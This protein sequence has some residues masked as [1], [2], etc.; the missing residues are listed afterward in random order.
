MVII[1][2]A[3]FLLEV[4]ESALLGRLPAMPVIGEILVDASLMVAVLSVLLHVFVMRPMMSE[5][6]RR[7]RAEEELRELNR[8]L[9]QQVAERT[10]ELLEANR[11]LNKAVRDQEDVSESLRRNSAFIQS[12]FNNAGCLLLAFDS[13]WHGCV[14]VNDRLTDLLGYEQD[15]FAAN[16][17]DVAERLISAQDRPG[18][19]AEVARITD[20]PAE[21]VVWRSFE[22]MTVGREPVLLSVGLSAVDLT[23]TGQAKTVLLTA[24]PGSS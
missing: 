21:G 12:V 3:V 22:F 24:M 2:G 20:R 10:D 23:P 5:I 8:T 9:E 6:Q 7:E 11:R 14:Y 15:T 1:A 17:G 16:S 18:F 13:G 4:G 19:L